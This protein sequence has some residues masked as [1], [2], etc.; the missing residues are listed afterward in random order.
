[1]WNESDSDI[2]LK[3]LIS[4]GERALA[5]LPLLKLSDEALWSLMKQLLPWHQVQHR[6]LAAL[7]LLQLKLQTLVSP[8]SSLFVQ[9]LTDAGDA[10]VP[11]SHTLATWQQAPRLQSGQ[12]RDTAGC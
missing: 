9:C 2:L 4:G 3:A 12:V 7:R 5:G 10:V 8:A 6:A 1:M 11:Q